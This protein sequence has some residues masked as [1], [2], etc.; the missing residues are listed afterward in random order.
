ML[1]TKKKKYLSIASDY[2][3]ENYIFNK[4]FIEDSKK[5]FVLKK[6]FSTNT[7]INLLYGCLDTAV[8]LEKQIKI[9]NTIKAKNSKLIIVKNSN[10]SMSSQTDLLLIER[11]LKNM[12]K[13]IL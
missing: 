12:I 1:N 6:A 9:L 11:T 5:Y 13:D 4:N 10:H 8:T 2:D 3:E 7:I